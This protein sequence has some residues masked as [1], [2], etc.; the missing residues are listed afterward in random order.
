MDLQSRNWSQLPLQLGATACEVCPYRVLARCDG[1]TTA[2]SYLMDD[3]S[4]IGCVRPERQMEVFR[5]LHGHSSASGIRKTLQD[6]IVVPNF[7]PLIKDGLAAI[8]PRDAEGL[9]A[10]SLQTLLNPSGN[11]CVL[12][13]QELRGKLGLNEGARLALIG[14]CKD[15][16]LERFWTESEERDVWR[17]ISSLGFEFA[18]TTTFSVW[19]DNPRFDQIFNQDRNLLVYDYLSDVGVPSIPFLLFSGE[20]CDYDHT[21]SWLMEHRAV[22]V[23]AVRGWNR[24]KRAEFLELIHDMRCIAHDVGRPLGFVVVGVSHP[25]R[26]AMILKEFD[27]CIV[28]AKPFMTALNGSRASSDLQYTPDRDTS[29]EQLFFENVVCYQTYCAG[30]TESSDARALPMRKFAGIAEVEQRDSPL[31]SVSRVALIDPASDR[32]SRKLSL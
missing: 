32:T 31:P 22:K 1:P 14:T 19:Y 16:K 25:I 4:V 8:S 6:S 24:T 26:I 2:E 5:D 7:I 20:R 12:T 28:S 29:R 18:T 13:P 23:V 30:V 3:P 9:V 10:V 15:K 21:I 11:L 27:A 17:R